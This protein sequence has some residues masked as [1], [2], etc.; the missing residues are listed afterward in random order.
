MVG[1][2]IHSDTGGNW[3][4]IIAAGGHT[5]AAPSQA[6]QLLSAKLSSCSNVPYQA[7][8]LLNWPNQAVQLLK[9]PCQAVQLLKSTQ[10]LE[11]IEH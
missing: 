2:Q 9:C 7:V 3:T 1:G 6:V 8:Q 5:P 11:E 4:L 10:T